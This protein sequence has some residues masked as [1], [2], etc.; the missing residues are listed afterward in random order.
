MLSALHESTL[1]QT[2][3]YLRIRARMHWIYFATLVCY[4]GLAVAWIFMNVRKVR[5]AHVV[6]GIAIA[7]AA[8]FFIAVGAFLGSF[9][10]NICYSGV[11]A[12]LAEYPAK[13]GL[14]AELPLRGYETSCEE[15]RVIV[16]NR[17]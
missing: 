7:L 16:E 4:V 12:T 5:G 8:P 9:D 6:G 10:S 1:D 11:I 15:V 3:A 17:K 14:R 13:P 2:A